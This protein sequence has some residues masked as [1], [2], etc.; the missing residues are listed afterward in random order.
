MTKGIPALW[1]KVGSNQSLTFIT[2]G[3]C[4]GHTEGGFDTNFGIPEQQQQAPSKAMAKLQVH[5]LALAA[6]VFGLLVWIIALGGLGA[7]TYKCQ[8]QEGY[9][10]CAKQYQ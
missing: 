9:A 4:D 2:I 5:P 6:V 10:L 3:D 8:Q 7:A 1:V